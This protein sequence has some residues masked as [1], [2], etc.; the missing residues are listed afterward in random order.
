MYLVNEKGNNKYERHHMRGS[1]GVGCAAPWQTR[2]G[3][4]RLSLGMHF[5]G[6]VESECYKFWGGLPLQ[7][8]SAVDPYSW[9]GV[10][11]LVPELSRVW[12]GR[13]VWDYSQVPGWVPRCWRH[14]FCDHIIWPEAG[15]SCKERCRAV[16]WLPSGGELVQVAGEALQLSPQLELF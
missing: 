9:I 1:D 5:S 16:N 8:A 11:F 7:I 12:C 15:Q 3:Q 6:G 4:Q 10:W 14:W 13:H 2:P